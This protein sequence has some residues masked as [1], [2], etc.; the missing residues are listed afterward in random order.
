MAVFPFPDL[1]P[2]CCC[3]SSPQIDVVSTEAADRKIYLFALRD[4]HEGEELTYD[5]Q[6]PASETLVR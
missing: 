4:I 5:Y 3:A 1:L 6:F 2:T